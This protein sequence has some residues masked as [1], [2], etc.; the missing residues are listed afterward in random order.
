MDEDIEREIGNHLKRQENAPEGM[1]VLDD[2][3]TVPLGG[4]QDNADE[5]E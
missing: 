5:D 4:K 1:V 2:G 3:R